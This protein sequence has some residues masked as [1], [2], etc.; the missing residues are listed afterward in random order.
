M[1]V[2]L[3][4]GR[5]GLEINLPDAVDVLAT[6][7]IPG[8]PDEAEGIRKALQEPIS[9]PPLSTL[10]E[11]GDRV[12]VVHT[13][14]TR[15][16]PNERI[17]PV[18]LDE[19]LSGGIA[20]QDITL[21][22]GLG[23]HRSQTENELRGMLGDQIVDGYRCLQH[24][25]NDDGNLVS[26]GETSL[27]N[28]V[29]INRHYMEADVRILTGFIEPHFFAGFS[30][31]PKAILP[32][33]AGTESVFSNHGLEM[34]AH[35]QAAWGITTGNPI[36]EEMGE[37][38]LRTD[39]TF[40]LNVAINTQQEITAVF[41]GDMLEAHSLGC[42]YVK[43]NAMVAV[44]ASYDIVITTNSGYPLDQNLYQSVKGMSAASQVVREGGAIIIATACEDGLPD[45]GRYASLLA[46]AGTPQGILD[47]ISQPGFSVQDQWQVQI[48]AQ[49]Q[50]RAEVY[51]Y[52]DGLTDD[53]I[54]QALFLPCR[55]IEATVAHL[56][57]RYGPQA[58]ICVMPEGP[59]LI[60]Y[61]SG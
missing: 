20:S 19:L 27:G 23:T 29:R 3:N 7:F 12:I 61:L 55:D 24:D 42:V 26:L 56:Q 38:A 21:L 13:D 41:A 11:A 34:I 46:E 28:P 49:I 48:Q 2:D 53:Q 14:I 60:P 54:Q 6:R 5:Q 44:D 39:P 22:N 58:R 35:P 36:W 59:Q 1:K 30:G 32:S 16:T 18:L 40:T 52:S 33:L 50:R 45:H 31:G 43:R 4:Y 51:V 17:L 37:V 57:E 8:I 15:A 10:V 47:L 9:S 25:C